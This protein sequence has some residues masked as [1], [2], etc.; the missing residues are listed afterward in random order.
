MQRQVKQGI[1]GVSKYHSNSEIPL[2]VKNIKK[3]LRF[4]LQKK[5]KKKAGITMEYGHP[6]FA[7]FDL[8]L[9]TFSILL[10][11]DIILLPVEGHNILTSG[12]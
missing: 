8:P 10:P 6:R 1:F 3:I 7:L 11:K 4:N 5:F 12:F 9:H 2:K